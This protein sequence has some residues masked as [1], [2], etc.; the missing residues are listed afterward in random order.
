MMDICDL[1]KGGAKYR[2]ANNRVTAMVAHDKLLLNL[3]NIRELG[4]APRTLWEVANNA[5]ER[6]RPSLPESVKV[7]NVETS[8]PAEAVAAVNHFYVQKV[9]KIR[10]SIAGA[11]PALASN[12]PP[13][14]K[15]FEFRSASASRITSIV[16]GLN[17]TEALGVDK[18]P[19]SV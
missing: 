19:V 8:G 5:L 12:W 2:R 4:N 18:V 11:P 9:D 14:S 15:P 10:E 3:T 17:P 7:N 6:S 16:K 1:A 13:R